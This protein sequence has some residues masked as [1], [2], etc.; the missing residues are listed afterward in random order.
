[1][2]D[3]RWLPREILVAEKTPTIDDR[4]C[5]VMTSDHRHFLRR[6]VGLDIGQFHGSRDPDPFGGDR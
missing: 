6:A 1:M 3:N 5:T 2:T 4:R